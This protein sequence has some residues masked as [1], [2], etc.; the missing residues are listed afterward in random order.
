MA[1]K[2]SLYIDAMSHSDAEASNTQSYYE[3]HRKLFLNSAV[4]FFTFVHFNRKV[5]LVNPLV[6]LDFLF[7]PHPPKKSKILNGPLHYAA[8]GS[9]AVVSLAIVPL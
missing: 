3:A 8:H 1:N 6:S 5:F 2:Y 7:S 4:V 9:C